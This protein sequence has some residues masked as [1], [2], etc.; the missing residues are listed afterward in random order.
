MSIVPFPV[1]PVLQNGMIVSAATIEKGHNSAL[2]YLLGESHASIPMA[3]W[4]SQT[5]VYQDAYVTVCQ[6]WLYHTSFAVYYTAR[7]SN[8]SAGK[9]AY[10]RLQAKDKD[11]IWRT[12]V[13]E[14][15]VWDAYNFRSGSLDL[16]N[17][18]GNDYTLNFPVNKI[19]EWRFQVKTSDETYHTRIHVWGVWARKAI[20][21][22]V[23]PHDFVADET[24][25]AG[26]FNDARTDLNLLYDQL[27][28][29]IP[30]TNSQNQWAFDDNNPHTYAVGVYRYRPESLYGVIEVGFASVGSNFRLYINFGDS[31][32]NTA[33]VYESGNIASTGVHQIVDATVDLTAGAAAAALAAA[34]IALA[35]GTYY[36]VSIGIERQD[37]SV[38]YDMEFGAIAR[39]SSGTPH[40]SWAAPNIW[41]EGDTDFGPTHLDKIK[42]DLEL[43][44]SGGDEEMWGESPSTMYNYIGMITQRYSVVHRKRWLIYRPREGDVAVIRYGTNYDESQSLT[45]ESTWQSYDL[46]QLPIP[47]GSYY[48]VTEVVG[49]FESDEAYS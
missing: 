38:Q 8:D 9:T 37:G 11:D 36:T 48:H 20:V 28:P 25:D 14:N 10:W 1:I 42:A 33:T 34:G 32:G 49:A 16:S 41:A 27:S 21:G 18:G 44:Y 24:S 47:W 6:V 40:G 2:W 23:A 12:M 26:H 29:V 39:V 17:V 19:Y 31:A 15:G 13:E 45:E 5:D 46:T 7:V 43:F 4:H 22:W 30:F 35:L 3:S